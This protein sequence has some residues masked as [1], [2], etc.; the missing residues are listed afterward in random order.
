LSDVFTDQVPD[1]PATS[2]VTGCVQMPAATPGPALAR[3]S[4][5]LVVDFIQINCGKRISAMTLL[6]TNTKNTIALIQE[7]YTSINGCTLLHKR[8]FFCWSAAPPAGTLPAPSAHIKHAKKTRFKEYVREV[9]TLPAMAKLSKILRAKP[10]SKLGLVKKPDGSLCTSP[11]ESLS[12]IVRN[13]SQGVLLQSLRPVPR[14][15]ALK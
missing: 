3:L 2:A 8:D 13:T 10:S 5:T 15:G 4:V 12:T 14:Q 1:I 9:E 7:P 11:E 6:E